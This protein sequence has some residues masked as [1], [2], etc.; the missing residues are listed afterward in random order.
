MSDVRIT[1]V[2]AIEVAVPFAEG[3]SSATALSTVRS[4]MSRSLIVAVDTDAGVTGVAEAPVR[5]HVYGDS[6]ASIR[7]AVEG[8]LAE[9]VV[10]R[11]PYETR[12]IVA[13]LDPP[14]GIE[15]NLV[16]K[17]AIDIAVHDVK[18][19]LLGSP[20]ADCL[21]GGARP[22][23]LALTWLL[24]LGD[25]DEVVGEARR[26]AGDGYTGFKVKVGRDLAH[27]VTLIAELR[28]ALGPDAF[29]Y[30]DANGSYTPRDAVTAAERFAESGVAYVEDPCAVT[31]PRR[32]RARLAAES[33]VPILGDAGCHTVD[34][35]RQELED[36]LIHAVLI[37]TAR[38]GFVSSGRIADLAAAFGVPCFAGTQGEGVLGT[39]TGWQLI[40]AF[41]S[42]TEPT[43]VC[44]MHKLSE[45]LAEPA[46]RFPIE[47]GRL[48]ADDRPGI[49]AL[50]LWDVIERYR[51][52]S[53]TG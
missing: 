2:R 24:P 39:L 53:A 35:V 47:G 10:G 27:D 13:S 43:E 36:G 51:S 6:A 40:Q 41:P 34:Q 23:G 26:V 25:V 32:A 38:T 29:V 8:R 52:P 16:A 46:G 12:G 3:H 4:T 42:I 45:Q 1:E 20:V 17:S 49:A 18:G 37:K 7:A 22:D 14:T 21:G 31:L 44:F 30:A 11:D 50:P 15:A 48:Y 28:G 9:C 33:A 19:Q 5:P